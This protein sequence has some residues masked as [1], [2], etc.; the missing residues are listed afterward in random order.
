MD[1]APQ[2]ITNP[3]KIIAVVSDPIAPDITAGTSEGLNRIS[4]DHDTPSVMAVAPKLNVAT[5]VA[6]AAPVLA[7]DLTCREGILAFGGLPLAPI[8]V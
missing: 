5:I 3:N 8:T 1:I 2:K 7:V 6:A 4:Y